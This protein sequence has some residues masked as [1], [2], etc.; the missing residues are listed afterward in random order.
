MNARRLSAAEADFYAQNGYVHVKGLLTREEAAFYRAEV[1]GIAERQG[2]TDATWAS[3]KATGTKITHC[4]DVHFR[5]AAFT[6]LL[7]DPRLVG[8]AQ[9]IIGPNVQLHHNKMFIKP[10]ERG[11]PFPMHQ[12]YPYFP[13]ERH[14]MIAVILHFDDAPEEKGCLRVYPGTHR[15]GPLEAVGDDHHLPEDRYP[16]EGATP[17]PAEAG[18]AIF[19][20]YLLVHGSGVNVSDEPRT[21]LLV[22]MRDPEDV[23]LNEGHASRGQ[24]MMLAGIDP[25][26]KSFAFAWEEEAA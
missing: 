8:V 23:P 21:T 7:V 1:H 9:D 4:H 25:T 15:L 16:I 22:Q 18:D 17:I 2:E 3:V 6:R 26:Q 24:G 5:S 11:S 19:L 14:S 20:S 10:P 13:H 12:D